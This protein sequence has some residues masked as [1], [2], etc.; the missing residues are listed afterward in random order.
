VSGARAHSWPLFGVRP[1]ADSRLGPLSDPSDACHECTKASLW[2]ALWPAPQG[3]AQNS[4][5][6]YRLSVPATM[7]AGGR[8]S[9]TVCGPSHRTSPTTTPF[10]AGSAASSGSYHAGAGAAEPAERSA[11]RPS[12]RKEQNAETRRDPSEFFPGHRSARLVRSD[13]DLR[14]GCEGRSE[15]CRGSH[16]ARGSSLG[17]SRGLRWLPIGEASDAVNRTSPF[18][19][20]AKFAPRIVHIYLHIYLHCPQRSAR[21]VVSVP[22]AYGPP[23]RVRIAKDKRSPC[24]ITAVIWRHLLG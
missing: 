8:P 10:A 6:T 17:A 22:S 15:A 16:Y 23:D 19:H 13:S 18:T 2:V 24:Q 5:A 7:R 9:R 12:S 14:V 1:S 11:P 4:E 3:R 21:S 20:S